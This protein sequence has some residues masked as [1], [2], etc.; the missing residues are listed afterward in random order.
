[1]I[2][3]LNLEEIQRE[4]FDYIMGI[5]HR[6]DKLCKMLFTGNK[7][8]P[9]RYEDYKGLKIQEHFLKIK[10][11]LVWKCREVLNENKIQIDQ[12]MY[13]SVAQQIRMLKND[14][15]IHYDE[16]K[17]IFQ[18]LTEK[19]NVIRKLIAVIRSAKANFEM[20]HRLVICLNE[21]RKTTAK[22]KRDNQI[23]KLSR[24]LNKLLSNSKDR[25]AVEI[26]SSFGK[27]FE[28]YKRRYK[29]FF[30]ITRE[31]DQQ[32]IIGYALDS[33]A[34]AEEEKQDGLFILKTSCQELE[35]KKIIDAYKNLQEV[36]LLFDDLKHFVDIRP[37]R[38]L[39]SKRV[40]AHVFVCMLA[41]LLKRIFEID[42]MGSKCTM[43]A[44]EEISKS[45]FVKYKV[46]FSEKEDR[47]MVVPKITRISET[48]AEIFKKVGVKNP[49]NLEGF[50]W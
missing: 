45:K 4:G 2:T 19:P 23:I 25:E 22:E 47:T 11:F 46:K 10:D 42:R 43:H 34:K 40:R 27:I 18:K 20:E 35:T 15:E 36:E 9:S 39:L 17:L 41:M 37:I 30:S 49:T 50:I 8:D 5:K 48:Q 32:K 16:W 24:E 12:N 31:G 6:Q 44:L 13:G 28:G 21:D 1:M 29:K 33:M 7:L 14:D 38:H 26:E 3:K